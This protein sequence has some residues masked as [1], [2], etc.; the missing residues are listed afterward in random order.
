LDCLLVHVPKMLEWSP[1]FGWMSR[2]DLL[3]MGTLS[4]A[5]ELHRAGLGVRVVH[6]G[7]EKQRDP[8]W[9]LVEHVRRSG[10]R[11][12]A[13]ALHWHPQ[14]WDMLEAARQLREALPD[15]RIVLGGL[16]AT[17][18]ASE[19]LARYPWVDAVIRGEAERALRQVVQGE[20]LATIPNLSWRDGEEI[21][22]NPLAPASDG[23]T[24]DGWGFDAWP[25]VEHAEDVLRQGWRHLWDPGLRARLAP[26]PEP[27]LFGAALGRGC[28]GTCTWC[29]GSYGPM[30]E[31]TGRRKT[32]WRAAE[33]VAATIEAARKAGARR[34]YTCFDP[35][36]RRE[37]E[38]LALLEVLGGLAPR[39]ALDFEA[40]GLPSPAV[41]EAFARHLDPSSTLI[42][43]PETADEALRRR[44]RAFPF[45]NADLYERLD[46]MGRLGV[47]SDLY[48]ILGLPG[49]DRAGVEATRD[50]QAALRRFPAVRRMYTWP[51]EMEPGAPW[52]RDPQRWG[53]TLRHRTVEDFAEAHRGRE[54]SLG[55]DTETL[56][57]AEILDLHDRWFTPVEPGVRAALRGYLA[58]RPLDVGFAR[59]FGGREP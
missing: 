28:L 31:A 30:K 32:A 14:T 27:T 3:S 52:H 2:I 12:A 9:S 29:A 49:E 25:L 36:P 1:L 24:M 18:F 47:R 45:S 19:I 23:T 15:V 42:V 6:V 54:F 34:I 16:T 38:L 58:A 56:K 44:H 33:R 53:L 43:S 35:H 8:R 48:F 4:I 51:L 17:H 11:I 37:D 41:V 26:N 55:Y 57:E 22:E 46:Q 39:V 59:D 5:E 13:F 20:P 50:F 10:A 21:R 40:F 7:V